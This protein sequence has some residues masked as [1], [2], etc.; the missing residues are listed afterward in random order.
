MLKPELWNRSGFNTSLKAQQMLVYKKT[1]L[2]RYYCIKTQCD[3]RKLKDFEEIAL[4][5]LFFFC[6]K[7]PAKKAYSLYAFWKLRIQ[8]KG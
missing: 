1:M 8:D 7:K 3:A 6:G 5:N 2:D 4:I